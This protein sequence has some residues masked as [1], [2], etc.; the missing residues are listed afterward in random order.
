MSPY[1]KPPPYLAPYLVNNVS[2]PRLVPC[3]LVGLAAG[4]GCKPHLPSPALT[5]HTALDTNHPHTFHSI[6]DYEAGSKPN[7]LGERAQGTRKRARLH[8][9]LKLETDSVT[10]TRGIYDGVHELTKFVTS[11]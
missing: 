4:R 9:Q 8:R 6:T 3:L 10:L 7:R 11:V 1:P 5:I 2:P